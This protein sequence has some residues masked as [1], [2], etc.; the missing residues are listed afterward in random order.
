VR[1]RAFDS[2]GCLSLF[3]REA[4]AAGRFDVVIREFVLCDPATSRGG[5][6]ILVNAAGAG[7]FARLLADAPVGLFGR[8]TLG[9]GLIQKGRGLEGPLC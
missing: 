5:M 1:W 6:E 7:P 9:V 4:W 2:P 8:N 3:F